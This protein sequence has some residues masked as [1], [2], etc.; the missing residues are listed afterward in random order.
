MVGRRS[1]GC[2]HRRY[3]WNYENNLGGKD[4]SG[5]HMSMVEVSQPL[6][7]A[8]SLYISRDLSLLEFQRRVL[9]QAQDEQTPLLER[10]KFLAIFGSNM[11]EFFMLRLPSLLRRIASNDGNGSVDADSSELR[12][13]RGQARDLYSSALKCLHEE[14]I[15]RLKKSG[16]RFLRYSDLTKH[17][18]ERVYNYFKKTIYPLFDSSAAGLRTHISSYLELVPKPC[19]RVAG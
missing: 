14:L 3:W 10:V 5:V 1:N 9:Q 2:S 11:D 13:I 15:P 19:C 18:K 16:I 17:Q 6:L 7:E 8:P 12:A 4:R